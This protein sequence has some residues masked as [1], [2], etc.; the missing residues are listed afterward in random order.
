M[1]TRN[2]HRLAGTTVSIDV[3]LDRYKQRL[4]DIFEKA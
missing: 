3:S 4:R 2:T 1:D